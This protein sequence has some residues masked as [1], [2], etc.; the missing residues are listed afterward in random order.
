MPYR[1]FD[2]AVCTVLLEVGC[3][4]S[5]RVVQITRHHL[6]PLRAGVSRSCNHSVR[7]FAGCD[8]PQV[9][10]FLP[11]CGVQ[12]ASL[13]CLNFGMA[14]VNVPSTVTAAACR[15]QYLPSW[16]SW[17]CQLRCATARCGSGHHAVQANVARLLHVCR[18]QGYRGC[19]CFVHAN[20]FVGM[21]K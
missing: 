16:P 11:H 8:T 18:Q 3:L 12:R 9:R 20:Q 6:F 15:W 19:T 4:R 2:A 13:E 7:Q 14:N 10:I 1:H 17:I 5:K 21:T